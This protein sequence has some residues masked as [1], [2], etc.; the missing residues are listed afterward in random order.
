M[1]TMSC[2]HTWAWVFV[3]CAG[4]YSL[5]NAI[6]PSMSRWGIGA[7]SYTILSSSSTCHGTFFPVSPLR[8]VA[9]NYVETILQWLLRLVP[10][11]IIKRTSLNSI[12]SLKLVWP[13]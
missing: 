8:P 4:N 6:L 5:P 11:S 7:S 9:I 3:A 10:F 13:V 12:V 1:H 2:S